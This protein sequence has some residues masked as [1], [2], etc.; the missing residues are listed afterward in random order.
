MANL[1]LAGLRGDEAALA[2]K[3]ANIDY[4]EY[5]TNAE[6]RKAIADATGML[7][8]EYLEADAQTNRQ[9]SREKERIELTNAIAIAERSAKIA[10]LDRKV[11]PYLSKVG[12][13]A[14]AGAE[15]LK[16]VWPDATLLDVQRDPESGRITGYYIQP[17][18][19][20]V[21]TLSPLQLQQEA[22]NLF[23]TAREVANQAQAT[24]QKTTERKQSLEDKDYE[25][26]LKTREDRNQQILKAQ[27]ADEADR[28]TRE[29]NSLQKY[30]D[31]T[32]SSAIAEAEEYLLTSNGYQIVKDSITGRMIPTD[33]NGDAITP[34]AY[35]KIHTQAQESGQYLYNSIKSGNVIDVA[36]AVNRL[37]VEKQSIIDRA[38]YDASLSTQ[39]QMDA[40]RGAGI[41][42]QNSMSA[43]L[44]GLSNYMQSPGTDTG[45]YSKE[46]L[47]AMSQGYAEKAAEQYEAYKNS[48][49]RAVAKSL[50]ERLTEAAQKAAMAREAVSN[51]NTRTR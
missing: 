2:N 12:I 40:R 28:N 44:Q 35:Q 1:I 17:A 26:R 22:L 31:T 3:R 42:A 10:E 39:K 20:E 51:M 11:Q 47:S 29:R 6:N 25:S 4:Q 15:V 24:I 27:L 9:L 14:E 18:G 21:I 36:Q 48:R 30:R 13:S 38:R 45:G 41:T 43:Q 8:K 23:S 7:S 5:V 32:L 33:L 49:M 34:E 16:Q 50:Q 46:A 37:G 19:K